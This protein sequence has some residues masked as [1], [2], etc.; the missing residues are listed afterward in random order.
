[1]IQAIPLGMAQAGELIFGGLMIGALFRVLEKTGMITAAIAAI[2]KFFHDRTILLIPTLM[3]PLA[4]FTTITGVLELN[5]L[6]IPIVVPLFRKQ[7]YIRLTALPI[8][9]F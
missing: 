4:I 9:I 1:M 8:V 2:K 3:L 5:L 6:Y 7:D